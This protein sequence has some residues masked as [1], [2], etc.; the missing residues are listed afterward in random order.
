LD[1]VIPCLYEYSIAYKD[2]EKYKA[3]IPFPINLD[4]IEY[5]EN[6][7]SNGKVVFFHGLI[8]ELEK[9]TVYIR[10]ALERLQQDFPN[11]V[12]VIIDG[13]MPFDRYVEVLNKANVVVDQCLSYG[14]GINACIAMA[15][16]KVVV[17]GCRHETI[18]AFGIDSTPMV[19]AKP[20]SG[21]LYEQ[22]KSIVERKDEIKEWGR[23][24]RIYVE[25]LHDYRQVAQQC[26]DVWKSTGKV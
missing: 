10:E 5:H 23:K 8:R 3:L 4:D 2:N 17:S 25:N 24:S 12:E 11:D 19:L 1:V 22:F 18:N 21:F 15:Q 13:H 16:G 6:I 7:L 9:G 14:Y 20:D 26:I